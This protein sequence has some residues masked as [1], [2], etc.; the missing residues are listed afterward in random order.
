MSFHSEPLRLHPKHP[1]G[2]HPIFTRTLP[3]HNLP[4]TGVAARAMSQARAAQGGGRYAGRSALPTPAKSHTHS[5][6]LSLK[7]ARALAGEHARGQPSHHRRGTQ[8][9][10]MLSPA[11]ATCCG[12][13]PAGRQQSLLP[14][15]LWPLWPPWPSR[16]SWLGCCCCCCCS[17]SVR[18]QPR[19]RQQANARFASAC[20]TRLQQCTP[21]GIFGSAIRSGAQLAR[22][23]TIRAATRRAAGCSV[24][25]CTRRGGGRRRHGHCMREGWRANRNR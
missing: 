5:A 2:H 21:C 10:R 24:R 8:P 1:T 18:P 15:P 9:P 20:Q 6:S 3:W 14:W 23:Q 17:C 4:P 12:T 13:A 22:A 11:A 7:V 16:P 25:R 19:L